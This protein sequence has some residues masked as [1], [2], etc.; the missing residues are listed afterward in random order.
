MIGVGWTL[1]NL[2]A[3]TTDCFWSDDAVAVL[4]AYFDESGSL[5]DGGE[6]AMWSSAD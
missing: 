4:Q 3:A 1:E 2:Y 6:T 5:K